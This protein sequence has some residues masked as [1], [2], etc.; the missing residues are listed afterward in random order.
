MKAIDRRKIKNKT[1]F[2]NMGF[3]GVPFSEGVREMTILMYNDGIFQN[4]E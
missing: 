2:F 1:L 3:S 4:K